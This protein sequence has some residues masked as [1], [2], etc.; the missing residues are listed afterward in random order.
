[1]NRETIEMKKLRLDLD[2]LRIDSFDA[3]SAEGGGGTVHARQL[4]TR[5]TFQTIQLSC[6]YTARYESCYA[7]CECTNGDIRCKDPDIR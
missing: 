7:A 3:G 5:T 6:D 4:T 2:T 1:L